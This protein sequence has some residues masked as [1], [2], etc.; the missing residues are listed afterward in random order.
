MSGRDLLFIAAWVSVIAYVAWQTS[1]KAPSPARTGG[2][3]RRLRNRPGNGGMALRFTAPP[4][5]H[6]EE[7]RSSEPVPAERDLAMITAEQLA[8][9]QLARALAGLTPSVLCTS[10]VAE[11]VQARANDQPDPE[12]LP[13]VVLGEITNGGRPSTAM[14]CLVRHSL[15]V[16]VPSPPSLLVAPANALPSGT[17]T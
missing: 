16:D 5:Y 12:V 10:C 15:T 8:P 1:R 6:P 4:R 17:L 7:D 2:R 9:D 13:G 11:L 14:L 3:G